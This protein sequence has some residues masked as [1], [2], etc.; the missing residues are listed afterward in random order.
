MRKTDTVYLE[1]INEAITTIEKY[2]TR[3]DFQIFT[4]E[5]MRQDAVIRQLEIIGEAANKLSAEFSQTNLDFPLRQTISLRNFLIHGYDE[6]NLD[7]V[8]KT[9]QEN[10]PPLKHSIAKILS[11]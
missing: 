11:K 10:L 3:I 9:V 2:V 7:I 6:I 5:Q 1:D 8:W 4:N